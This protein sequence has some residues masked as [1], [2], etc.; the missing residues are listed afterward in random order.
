MLEKSDGTPPFVPVLFRPD[1]GSD[2]MT[3]ATYFLLAGLVSISFSVPS[4][5]FAV[6]R[7]YMLGATIHEKRPDEW[8]LHA[9]HRNRWLVGLALGRGRLDIPGDVYSWRLSRARMFIHFC[10]FDWIVGFA[11]FIGYG[12]MGA[13]N[14]F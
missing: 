6:I 1:F 3:T 4:L 9:A 14:I 11:G 12:L 2:Q 5:G 8:A 13:P 10:I 7:L